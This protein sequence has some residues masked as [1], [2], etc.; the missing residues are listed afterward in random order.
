MSFF[1]CKKQQNQ[2]VLDPNLDMYVCG[3]YTVYN[4]YVANNQYANVTKAVYWK[5]GTL[6]T[7]VEEQS[8]SNS[9][10]FGIVVEQNHVYVAGM[11]ENN[12][13][14]WVDGIRHSLMD[15]PATPGTAK[16]IVAKEGILYITGEAETAV[17]FPYAAFLWIVK[18]PN[19]ITQI[20]LAP[21][22]SF[23]NDIAL[24]AS[25]VYVAGKKSYVPCYW[26]WDGTTLNT[27][28]LNNPNG[29]NGEL[30]S[31]MVANG[32]VYSSGIYDTAGN[33]EFFTGYWIDDQ[34]YNSGLSS[35]VA[36]F[37]DLV[38]SPNGDL[39][40]VGYQ[41]D[42]NNEMHAACWKSVDTIP[43]VSSNQISSFNKIVF[44]ENDFYMCGR[45]NYRAS[46]WKNGTELVELSTNTGSSALDIFVVKK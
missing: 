17:N 46:Y 7:L 16:A 24:T 37:R 27:F 45:N 35:F 4:M 5:N 36:Q 39:Y 31:V 8:L 15:N 32:K 44:D 19:D 41:K 25:S 10:A 23:A 30:K 38:F 26:Q 40:Q 6:N 2:P 12:P 28:T 14:Y 18:A 20:I 33:G 43:L 13:C 9:L 1:A 21:S 3:N 11:Y 29:Y 42:Q 34:F 22:N